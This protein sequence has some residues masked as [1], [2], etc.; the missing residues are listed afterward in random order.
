MVK[1]L[2]FGRRWLHVLV[3]F[4]LIVGLSSCQALLD[5]VQTPLDENGKRNQMVANQLG[6]IASK[7]GFKDGS[8]GRDCEIEFDCTY[9]GVFSYEQD[10]PITA[11][12]VPAFCD[13]LL[14]FVAAAKFTSWNPES[15]T[16]Q[17]QDTLNQCIE[18]SHPAG[19]NFSVSGAVQIDGHTVRV[20]LVTGVQEELDK[21]GKM[22]YWISVTAAA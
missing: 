8:V 9:D 12:A 2:A 15:D 4:G 10:G 5:K 19:A 14:K 3:G 17:R 21:Q 20:I 7:Y 1:V 16:K 22:F 13:R 11:D 18:L 6:E